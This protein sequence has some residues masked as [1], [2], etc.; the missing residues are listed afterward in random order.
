MT[1][2]PRLKYMRDYTCTSLWTVNDKAREI[3]H[4]YNVSYDK[5]K[6]S[7]QLVESLE[8]M[9]DQ[10]YTLIDWNNPGAGCQWD[11][12]HI[13]DYNARADALYIRLINEIG[14]EYDIDNLERVLKDE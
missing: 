14:D 8:E 10:F 5:L 6:L 1:E 2:K 4:G 11:N 13:D 7:P 3:L 12:A 9:D